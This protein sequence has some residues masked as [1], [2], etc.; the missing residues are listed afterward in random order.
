MLYLTDPDDIRA[1]IAEYAE[2]KLIWVDTEI[3]DFQTRAPKLSLIQL[4]NEPAAQTA[5]NVSILDILDQPELADVFIDQIM[6]NSAIEKVFHNA[7]YDL[8]FLG[9]TKAKNVT[10]TL[11]IAKNIPYYMLPLP[12]FSLKT[13][14]ET[15]CNV[16]AVDKSQQSSDWGQRPLDRKQLNYAKMDPVYLAMVHRQLLQLKAMSEPDPASEDVA[17]LAERYLE[18][19]EQLR[20]LD[21]ELTHIETR[22]K[23]AMQAKSLTETNDLKLSQSNRKTLKVEFSHLAEAIR[24]SGI[25]VN[26][27]LTLT[28]KLQKQVENIIEQLNVT[29]EI[30]TSWRLSVKNGGEPN[31]QDELE[32]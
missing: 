27:P 22:L 12:N 26:F 16:P 1:R 10:C 3:A 9:K 8:K 28:Q 23:T 6:S 32:F 5:E 13:L 11:E 7:K 24:E 4:L 20:T 30:A 15:L 19:K 21:S 14:V 29:E 31:R 17:L 2:S 25:E 18:L